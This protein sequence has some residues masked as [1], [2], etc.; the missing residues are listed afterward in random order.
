[1]QVADY[2]GFGYRLDH[3]RVGDNALEEPTPESPRVAV[4]VP[5]VV[6]QSAQSN[7]LHGAREVLHRDRFVR[8]QPSQGDTARHTGIRYSYPQRLRLISAVAGAADVNVR[9]PCSYSA[10]RKRSRRV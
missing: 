4:L 5:K 2:L 6:P 3:S 1:V 10:F 7:A 8:F 9:D